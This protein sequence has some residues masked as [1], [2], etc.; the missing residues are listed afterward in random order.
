MRK[1]FQHFQIQE[2]RRRKR[3]GVND[4]D[5]VLEESNTFLPGMLLLRSPVRDNV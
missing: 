4:W 2:M 5:T 3:R 1:L